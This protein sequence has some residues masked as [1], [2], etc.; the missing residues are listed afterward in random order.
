MNTTTTYTDLVPRHL[1]PFAALLTSAKM[2]ATYDRSHTDAVLLRNG[3]TDEDV[4]A[5]DT[6]IGKETERLITA[7]LKLAAALRED[8]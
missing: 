1:E 3:K 7:A 5:Y 6:L 8:S 4:M 2:L